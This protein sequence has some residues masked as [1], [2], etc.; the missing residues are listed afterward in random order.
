MAGGGRGSAALP[1]A[2]VLRA[3]LLGLE[4]A[5]SCRFTLNQ[6]DMRLLYAR[7]AAIALIALFGQPARSHAQDFTVTLLGTGCPRPVMNRFGASILL[8]AGS[9]AFLFD[10]GRGAL[11]RLTQLGV[12]WP[13]VKGVFFT[14]LH[15]DHVVG[16]PDLY[17]TGWLLDPGR[18]T[19]LRVWGPAG[20]TAMTTHLT[21]AFT[22]DISYR[23]GSE[24]AS[25]DGARIEARDISEGFVHEE[26]GVRIA[27]F[28]IDH[29]TVKRA[30]GYRI[31]YGGRSVVLSGDTRPSENLVRRAAGSEVLIH[32]VLVPAALERAGVAAD[33]I[34]AIIAN[35]TTPD[36]A[37]DI[38]RRVQP[39]LAVY[40]HICP[41]S[42][43]PDELLAATR[44]MFAGKVE[45][46]EDLMVIEIGTTIEIR[47]PARSSP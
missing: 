44:K 27:A 33:R 46:G 3:R 47:R 26:G 21:A 14:H 18:S 31:D 9:Q 34:G 16:F 39:K 2:R 43:S 45:V 11:Q 12:R 29:G 1:L 38:F 41:P 36:Q 6:S 40:S 32:E 42:S 13:D 25:A 23:I 28:A 17:L 20:T 24:R 35:H 10:A 5:T 7:R 15:S 30:L 22:D 8:R 4:A 37:A 19:P